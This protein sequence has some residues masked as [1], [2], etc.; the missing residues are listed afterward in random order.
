MGA[1][2][3]SKQ[4]V[5]DQHWA[6]GLSLSDQPKP[7]LSAGE[8]IGDYR[9]VRLLG[10]GA[11]G[12]VYLVEDI[13]TARTMAL[14][15]LRP[16]W[17]TACGDDY[18][19]LFRKEAALNEPLEHPRIVKLLN[20]GEHNEL[21]FHV[22]EYI[23]GPTLREYRSGRML[24][25]VTASRIVADV[26]EAVHH[27]HRRGIVH[28]DLKPNNILIDRQGC[29]HVTDFGIALEHSE[30]G[31]GSRYVGTPLYM[32]PEQVR[33]SSHHLDGRS[34][35]Y[36][37]GV[38]LYELV[39]GIHPTLPPNAS[40]DSLSEAILSVPA[41]PMRQRVDVPSEFDRICS[42]ALAK[43]PEVRFHT[44]GDFAKAL[45][46]F[47]LRRRLRMALPTTA[48]LLLLLAGVIAGV[49]VA[50]ISRDGEQLA[51]STESS[52]GQELPRRSGNIAEA[53]AADRVAGE[54]RGSSDIAALDAAL[55]TVLPQGIAE[56]SIGEVGSA[57]ALI[58]AKLQVS[59]Q[60]DETLWG[61]F[62]SGPDNTLQTALI[63][64]CASARVDAQ[65]LVDR[66]AREKQ[67]DIRYALI[68][69]LGEYDPEKWDSAQRQQYVLN[70]LEWYALDADAGAHAAC[71][72]LLRKWG[73][74]HLRNE[75]KEQLVYLHPSS[76][77]NWFETEGNIELVACQLPP[78][79]SDATDTNHAFAI[80]A[81]EIAQCQWDW[82]MRQLPLSHVELPQRLPKGYTSWH[83]CAAFCNKLSTLA[84]IP[85]SEHCYEQLSQEFYR[86]FPDATQRRGFRLPTP[87]EWTH[88]GHANTQTPRYWGRND[89]LFELYANCRPHSH[90]NPR[91]PGS[92]K[93]NA[94]GLFDI[95]GNIS[96]W[97][98]PPEQ[99]PHVMFTFSDQHHV[100]GG[101]AWTLTDGVGV[102]TEYLLIGNEPA[103]RVGLRVAR[104]LPVSA[105]DPPPAVSL[106]AERQMIVLPHW[107]EATTPA[108]KPGGA[109]ESGNN[110]LVHAVSTEP[111][112]EEGVYFLGKF[113]RGSLRQPQL[114]IH[115]GSAQSLK[116]LKIAVSGCLELDESAP[117]P[118]PLAPKSSSK[119][120]VRVSKSAFGKVAGQLQLRWDDAE[121]SR[122]TRTVALTAWVT[123]PKL[124]TL[125]GHTPRNG[126]LQ[127]NFG[128]VSPGRHLR[129]MI[130][131][132]NRGDAQLVFRRTTT[133]GAVG[134]V[135]PR[136]L[137]SLLPGEYAYVEIDLD[138]SNLGIRQGA[139]LFDTNDPLF[140]TLRY[141][142][143]L[144][145]ESLPREPSLGLFHDGRWSLDFNMDGAPEKTLTF[146]EVGDRPYLGDM[147]GDRRLDLLTER[148]I[149]AE[150]CVVSI[151]FTNDT[152]AP[153]LETRTYPVGAGQWVILDVNRDGTEDI[154]WV[155]PDEERGLLH[156][157]FDT[158]G[159]SLWDHSLFFGFPGDK[160]ISGD[161]NGDGFRQLGVVRSTGAGD[162]LASWFLPVSDDLTHPTVLT[163]GFTSDT[164]VV[165]DWNGDGK[166]DIGVYRVVD[167]QGTFLLDIDRDP[168]A[169]LLIRMG[170]AEDIPL[171]FKHTHEL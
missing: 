145:V 150:A 77:R 92:L 97:I 5:R 98:H 70:V 12:F 45:R 21:P 24:D 20:S 131:L 44:A 127:I 118:G 86:P 112:P 53:V 125:E 31:T 63:H 75:A 120:P 3:E 149:N 82:V 134:M 132:V 9:V 95:L 109:T 2:E 38:I 23:E 66:C 58:I 171:A 26:A 167:G 8:C 129:H 73:V 17:K 146:G 122:Q 30:L 27:S 35:V 138:T 162:S 11:I 22:F 147:N 96:E 159:D 91:A 144:N 94:F 76:T 133:T 41:P 68:L 25:P 90:L 55:A 161:W 137:P 93:P 60:E 71:A 116:N 117:P 80:S 170:Q 46:M 18:R 87:E 10:K 139:I 40:K 160:A 7:P 65:L 100:R 89:K 99:A 154:G 85:A 49:R 56:S 64:M 15:L 102:N 52:M 126:A 28:R 67:P 50:W 47:V 14:K 43:D 62:A 88:A 124:E 168:D 142:A 74:E 128:T 101:S 158:T 4:T 153:Q 48:A 164:P 140:P 119:L 59:G 54:E 42:R 51:Q 32:S 37:L 6:L 69:A 110:Y 123:G 169:E 107:K 33:G 61:Y 16:D 72:W 111:I 36:S 156:W 152:D 81:Y 130:T 84:G 105:E 121:G 19:D 135:A 165:G 104:T 1:M 155:S 141:E 148:R 34:D 114:T 108:S 83:Q 79:T 13:R 166:D 78:A 57:A 39:T 115:N 136:E 157:Q 143:S 113:V 29:A 103:Q 163:F 151:Q 106:L